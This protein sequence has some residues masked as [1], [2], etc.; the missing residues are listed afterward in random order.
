MISNI[1]WVRLFGR[2]S[3]GVISGQAMSLT[4]FFSA[5]GLAAFALSLDYGASFRPAILVSALGFMALALAALLRRRPEEAAPL[6]PH[7]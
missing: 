1:A 7:L 4:V 5:V 2:A 3:L 6:G